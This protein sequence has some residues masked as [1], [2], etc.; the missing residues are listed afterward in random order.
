MR[1]RNERCSQSSAPVSGKENVMHSST[2]LELP[3]GTKRR[4]NRSW[5][6]RWLRMA[7]A[8]L[9]MVAF[10]R[11]APSA[12]ASDNDK[13]TGRIE[14]TVFVVIRG[15]QSLTSGAK[16]QA[17]G[18]IHIGAETNAGGKYVFDALPPGTY[19]IE[20]TSSGLEATET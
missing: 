17:S 1:D 2:K 10:C 15:H 11:F 18:P 20:V 4:P 19:T 12:L 8:V 13:P 3:I 6:V 9:L 14:G 7:V 5:R 16:V